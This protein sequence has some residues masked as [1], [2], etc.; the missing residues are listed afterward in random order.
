MILRFIRIEIDNLANQETTYS[1]HF[2][3]DGD[4]TEHTGI[5]EIEQPAVI[6]TSDLLGQKNPI[7]VDVVFIGFYATRVSDAL[8]KISN[9]NYTSKVQV[10]NS[11]NSRD[12]LAEFAKIHWKFNGTCTA[13]D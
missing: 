3:N 6:Q 1:D 10:Y 5:P 4:D 8:L 13:G 9:V 7:S 2:G 11:T 12:V